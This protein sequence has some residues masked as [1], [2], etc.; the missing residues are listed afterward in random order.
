MTELLPT[1]A[2]AAVAT[3]PAFSA[4]NDFWNLHA[5]IPLVVFVP[6]F[7]VIEWTGLDRTL[8]HALFYDP[9][10]A[11]WL[12]QGTGDW[13]AHGL[14]HDG[15]RWITRTVAGSALGLWI[16]SFL[17]ARMRPWRRS[18]GFV[19]FAM[20]ASVL[21]VGALKEVTNVDCPWDLVEFGGD[22]PYVALFSLRPHGL[23]H[24]ECFPGAHSS[25]AFALVCFY[26]LLRDRSRVAAAAGLGAAALLWAVF[27][28]GQEAR[29]AHFLTHDLASVAVVWFVQLALYVKLLRQPHQRVGSHA[30]CQAAEDV[31]RER[32]PDAG[33]QHADQPRVE[34]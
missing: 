28:L 1:P 12:G 30:Q 9:V 6:L 11:Q 33:G 22:R 29:G 20:A 31:A 7:C 4:L 21:I 19:F 18:A 26:F 34:Q 13:W 32:Q 10:R 17:S 24:A 15:G 14:I 3:C 27:A 23:A 16:A 25:S 5:W 8:A 2:G